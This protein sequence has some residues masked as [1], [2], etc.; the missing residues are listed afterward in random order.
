ML[1]W[2]VERMRET[3]FDVFLKHVRSTVSV[4]QYQTQLDLV[5]ETFELSHKFWAVADGRPHLISET[6]RPWVLFYMLPQSPHQGNQELNS[7]QVSRH[8]F[9]QVI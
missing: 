1:D 2:L 5:L 7:V 8:V 9:C 3:Q 4:T 6:H